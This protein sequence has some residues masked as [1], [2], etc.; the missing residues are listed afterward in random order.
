MRVLH[1][2]A[3]LDSLKTIREFVMQVAFDAGLE[4]PKACRLRLGVDEIAANIIQHG[5]AQMASA[6]IVRVCAEED[7]QC[8]K[9]ILEDRGQP[10]DPRQVPP[11]ENFEM[12]LESR[13]VGGLG[14]Y[15]TVNSVDRLEYERCGA[16]NRIIV[17]MEKE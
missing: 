2:P 3:D 1:V 6:Q 7:A 10:Y 15:L 11:L 16:W 4:P 14:L 12:P 5:Y 13:Q 17:I 8:L 9:I